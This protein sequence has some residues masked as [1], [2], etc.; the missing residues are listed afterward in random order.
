M[1]Y[2][3]TEKV[4]NKKPLIVGLIILIV[5]GLGVVGFALANNG[6]GKEY[7]QEMLQEYEEIAEIIEE[8]SEDEPEEME[9]RKD[10][11]FNFLVTREVADS[12]LNIMSLNLVERDDKDKYYE[13][14]VDNLL[15]GI[16][17]DAEEISDGTY[18]ITSFR[19]PVTKN[20]ELLVP[21]H[22][23]RYDIKVEDGIPFL[24]EKPSIGFCCTG[25]ES[26]TESCLDECDENCD[27]SDGECTE[28]SYDDLMYVNEDGE[29]VVNIPLVVVP[30]VEQT[31]EELEY[32][33]EVLE[34]WLANNP[35]ADEELREQVEN[36]L[37]TAIAEQE[38][39]E[40]ANIEDDEDDTD[41]EDVNDDT[42]Q[43]GGTTPPAQNPPN[44]PPVDGGQGGGG[45]QPPVQ[46]PPVQNPPNNPPACNHNWVEGTTT[47]HHPA[48]PGTPTWIFRCHSCN[49]SST[50]GY[51]AWD[52]VEDRNNDCWGFWAEQTGETGG[53]PAW[54]ETIGNG[55][56]TCSICGVRR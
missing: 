52:H 19:P 23:L 26:C 18:H 21:E 48:I 34:D 4:S 3:R 9:Q 42:V 16:I 13:F 49:F 47:I 27:C 43:D 50:C 33:I 45:T 17:V 30:V 11:N 10:V 29:I 14:N 41:N 56:W 7:T 1:N 51:A 24:V 44:N 20:A 37:E 22:R 12:V 28:I 2:E 46:N 55:V 40:Q 39:R 6:N 31:D 54:T 35:D 15:G 38:Y 36:A 8:E 53:T 5:L 25:M 32:V